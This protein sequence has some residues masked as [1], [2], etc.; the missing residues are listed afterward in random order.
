MEKEILKFCL[1]KGLLVDKSALDLFEGVG[2]VDSAKLIIEGFKEKTQAKMLTRHVFETHKSRVEEVILDLPFEKQ[3][4]LE[5]LKIKLGLTIEFEK[6]IA[7]VEKEEKTIEGFAKGV[8]RVKE[9]PFTVGKK[10]QVKDFVTHFRRRF[11]RMSGI[12][13]EHSELENL[14]SIDKISNTRQSFS[15]IGIV[16]DRRITKNKNLMLEVEDL[17]G[18]IKVLINE[19]KKEV[20]EQAENICLDGMMGFSGTGNREII[21]VNDVVFPEAF[22]DERKKGVLDENV[23]FLGDLHFGSDRFLEKEFLKFIDYLNGGISGTEE[24]VSKIKYLLLVG[25]IITGV[26]NYPNQEA[27]LKI[28]DL[29]EQFKQLAVLLDKIPKTIKIIL[30]PGNHDSVRLMEP[31]PLL[32]EKYAWPLYDLENAIFTTNPAR[33]NIGSVEELGFDGFDVLTYHGFSFPFY[34]NNIPELIAKRAMN[35]PE[36]IMKYLLKNRHLAP[37]HKSV[38]YFPLEKDA[39]LI[40]KVPDIFVSAHTHKSGAS[41]YNNILVIS[42]S[43]W[44]SMTPYQEKFGNQPD[45]CKVPM[46]NLK[47]RQVKILDFEEPVETEEVGV[48][49]EKLKVGVKK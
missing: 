42:T 14:I 6:E 21:F 17:T 8:V 37:T 4:V 13:Q 43:C 34:A 38:Q 48:N 7:I 35:C 20:F 23:L 24:E 19:N 5:K 18:K 30:S 27:E 11:D 45:H 49:K 16:T 10:L 9:M 41:Y 28:V 36:E 46:F 29:E 2:D 31:Q 39:L 32:D 33:V 3:K 44:E 47:T 15:I 26:G 22:I 12:L 40:K 25:D 1:E